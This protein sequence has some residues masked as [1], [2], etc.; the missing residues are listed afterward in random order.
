MLQKTR[1]KMQ[2]KG[3]GNTGI[4]LN[5]IMHELEERHVPV[6]LHASESLKSLSFSDAR[7]YRGI[8]SVN[9]GDILY[10]CDDASLLP[11]QAGRTIAV[12]YVTP[13]QEGMPPEGA[14][15]TIR[16]PLG[17]LAAF[18]ILQ[19]VFLKYRS[20][21]HELDQS[22]LKKEGVQAILDLS[23]TFLVNNTVVVDPALKLLAYTRGIAC[24]DP[25]TVELIK[26][27]YHTEENIRKFKLHKRFAPWAKCDGFIIN[28]THEICKYVTVVYSFKMKG[29]F[30]LIVIMMCNNL[31]PCSYLYDVLSILIERIDFYAKQD[32]PAD[33]PSGNAVDTFL[34]DLITKRLVDPHTIQ[35]R[36]KYVGIPYE[37]NFC[38]SHIDASRDSLPSSR[39]LSD[40][41]REIAPA[42]ALVVEK[43]IVV[44]CFNCHKAHCVQQ[45]AARKCDLHSKATSKRLDT[46]LVHWGL[47]CGKSSNFENLSQ[48]AC[49][50]DQAKAAER[51]GAKAAKGSLLPRTQPSWKT[52]FPFDQYVV[53]YLVELDGSAGELVGASRTSKLLASIAAYD[54]EHGTDNYRFLYLYLVHERR[55]SLV[56][57]VTHMHRNNVKNRIER[58]ESL[59]GIDTSDP[60][61]S[62]GLLLAYRISDA[63]DVQFAH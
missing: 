18:D 25:I 62:I 35:E 49:A 2:K 21:E 6:C 19:D 33:K 13:E 4:T 56:A 7:I 42:K 14:V 12:A 36:C 48:V 27:G 39:L 52:I 1:T 3:G 17:T 60:E 16:S 61:T 51:L 45:C 59:F 5:I 46:L 53:D 30:S 44:L 8:E 28:D 29:S 58:I 34:R 40:V 43:G 31:E 11:S 20:W 24:D 54:R 32:Y 57:E 23:E 47:T 10:L 22:C 50:F 63:Y 41:A 37:A 15:L 26:Y 9:C 55:P 38:L